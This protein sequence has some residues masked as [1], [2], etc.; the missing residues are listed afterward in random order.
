MSE[1]GY[2]FIVTGPLQ[3]EET[4]GNSRVLL[5]GDFLKLNSPTGN[6]REYQTDEGPQIALNLLGMP[7]YYG[8]KIGFDPALLKMGY[9][10]LK[11][12]ADQVGRVVKTV[13][14]KVGK[15]IRGTVEIFNTE[16]NPN[17]VSEVGPG[18]GFSIGGIVDKF[19]P[20]GTINSFGNPIVK[21]IGMIANHLQLL[22]PTVPRGQE[23]AKVH[24][25]ELVEET[26]MFD[27]CPWGFCTITEEGVTMRTAEETL[28]VP[29]PDEEGGGDGIETPAKTVIHKTVITKIN[30]NIIINEDPDTTL[31]V[32]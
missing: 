13:F 20:T 10:H 1:I 11:D 19:L 3:V 7:V 4:I 2:R 30:R 23:A 8:A 5:T 27:P 14:D 26:L 29:N 21:A 22:R 12:K 6:G 25:V 24:G 17:V 28:N 9:K 18:W 16:K 31:I 32:R 15:I